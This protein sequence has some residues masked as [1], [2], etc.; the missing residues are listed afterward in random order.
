MALVQFKT[1]NLASYVALAEKDANTLYFC[2]DAGLL[3]K[4]STLYS[5]AHVTVSSFPEE[6]AAVRNT[7][8]INTTTGEVRY[9]N[10]SSYVT[11]VKPNV[12]SVS[13]SSTNAQLPT[14]KAVYD[15]VST[16]TGDLENQISA[17]VGT[18]EDTAEDDTINGLRA[19][20][21]AENTRATG[22]EQANA[23]AISAETTRAQGVEG[24]LE[25]L[26]TTAK[27]NLVAA[28]NEVKT[29][30]ANAQANAAVTIS[31]STTTAGMLKSYTFTQNGATIGTI[32]IP[33]DLVVSSG[34]LIVVDA[35]HPVSGLTNGTYIKLVIA[36]QTEPIYI[37]VKD[38]I[39]V[40]TA[41]QNA[42]QI[43]L[44]VNAGVISGEI[45]DGSVDADAL[46]TD[47]VTTVKIA[48]ANVTKAKLSQAVQDSLDAADTAVQSVV[49]GTTNGTI[50]VD[51]SE[52][53]VV[54]LVDQQPLGS[55]DFVYFVYV[56]VIVDCQIVIEIKIAHNAKGVVIH[57]IM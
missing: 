54:G 11:M 22:A 33:K 49:T 29:A 6:A 1:G 31:D 20:I 56:N 2:E 5:G 50:S 40:Y 8:Y 26:T 16:E 44:A 32:D 53:G 9:F 28:I 48:N 47:A 57:L 34:E 39:D 10:G 43:Q 15:F 38:L 30:A 21:N 37:D 51:G 36:N 27:T 4:G 23:T 24:S 42:T 25:N 3:Y 7:I 46:G 18:N 52:V 19:A 13:E 45:V 55:L 12:T 35:E 14:A 17:I 41:E